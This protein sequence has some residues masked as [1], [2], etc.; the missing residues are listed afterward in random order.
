MDADELAAKVDK[1]IVEFDKI[2][3]DPETI[4]ESEELHRVTSYLSPADLLMRFT[5]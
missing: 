1:L 3:N 4:R 2:V 5:I